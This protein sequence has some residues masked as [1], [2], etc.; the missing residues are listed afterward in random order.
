MTP[1]SKQR[2]CDGFASVVCYQLSRKKTWR[3]ASRT[4]PLH[5]Q[6]HATNRAELQ[7]RPPPCFCSLFFWCVRSVISHGVWRVNGVCGTGRGCTPQAPELDL[8]ALVELA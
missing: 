3:S 6:T 1:A 7:R 4:T 5:T 8:S 2:G